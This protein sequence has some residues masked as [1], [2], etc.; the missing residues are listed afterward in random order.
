MPPPRHPSVGAPVG[1]RVSLDM[2]APPLSGV[3]TRMRR[4]PRVNAVLRG[5][6]ASMANAPVSPRPAADD[7]EFAGDV[8]DGAVDHNGFVL[9]PRQLHA[10]VGAAGGG[11]SPRF[12]A[13]PPSAQQFS[14]TGFGRGGR[15]G[16]ASSAGPSDP[17]ERT[18]R[19][20]VFDYDDRRAGFTRLLAS[21]SL[22][23]QSHF[24]A[25][26]LM[27]VERVPVP[28]ESGAC[29]R[30]HAWLLPCGSVC[31]VRVRACVCVCVGGCWRPCFLRERSPARFA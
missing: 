24:E 10:N 6:S 13:Q 8:E 22:V 25:G 29:V 14:S 11:H 18:R 12:L 30:L 23:F 28:F 5:R 16:D 3:P 20:V 19:M 26:N 4:M 17:H 2:H 27:R 7:D 1:A 31:L 15:N 21:D 9:S